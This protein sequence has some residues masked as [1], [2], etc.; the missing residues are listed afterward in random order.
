MRKNSKKLTL[1]K[2]TIRSLSDASLDAT[3]GAGTMWTI[4]AVCQPTVLCISTRM[5]ICFAC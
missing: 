4:G 1:D 2:T 5:S 3:A